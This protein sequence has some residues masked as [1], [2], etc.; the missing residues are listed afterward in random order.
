MTVRMTRSERASIIL[1]AER[2]IDCLTVRVECAT[3]SGKLAV[4]M[5]VD[6]LAEFRA[7]FAA[8]TAIAH[9]AHIAR[10]VPVSTPT[11]DEAL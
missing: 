6:E 10:D 8:V 1:D 2:A 11:G 9:A 7:R 3:G 4:A 5:S